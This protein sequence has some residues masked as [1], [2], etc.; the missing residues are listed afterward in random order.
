MRRNLLR[1]QITIDEIVRLVKSNDAEE[2]RQLA[3]KVFR[4]IDQDGDKTASW[5]EISDF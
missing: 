5:K 2:V 3:E 4:T 1:E